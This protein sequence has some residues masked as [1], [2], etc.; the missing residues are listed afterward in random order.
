M[1]VD[2]HVRRSLAEPA[3]G[4]VPLRRSLSA[5]T[6][7]QGHVLIGEGTYGKVFKAND[8]KHGHQVA[9]KKIRLEAED[10]GVPSTALRE[11]ALLKELHHPNVVRCALRPSRRAGRPA[12]GSQSAARAGCTTSSRPTASSRWCSSSRI[13]TSRAIW[14]RTRSCCARSPSSP[15]RAPPCEAPGERGGAADSAHWAA[16]GGSAPLGALTAALAAHAVAA[17]SGGLLSGGSAL[18]GPCSARWRRQED[19]LAPLHRASAP[20]AALQWPAVRLRAVGGPQEWRHGHRTLRA[21][22]DPAPAQFIIWQML[23]GLSYVHQRRWVPP[24]GRTPHSPAAP[25][26]DCPGALRLA[27]AHVLAAGASV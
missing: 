26:A 19:H 11:I 8:I 14:R 9:L 22:A 16:D 18:A 1:E 23:H 17:I 7:Y 5:A 21:P 15:R 4:D 20:P 25:L 2:T 24:L 12:G 10:E 3:P 13:R 27:R 6:R